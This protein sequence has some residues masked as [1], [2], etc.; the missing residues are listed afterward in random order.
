M[1]E[2][3]LWHFFNALPALG[4]SLAGSVLAVLRPRNAL[5]WLFLSWGLLLAL[6]KL[7]NYV[8]IAQTFDE[9]TGYYQASNAPEWQTMLG[10]LLDLGSLL[11]AMTVILALYPDGRLPA[12]WWRLPVTMVSLGYVLIVVYETV[13]TG[14]RDIAPLLVP[15]LAGFLVIPA[16][17]VILGATIHRWR[18]AVYPYRQQ[19]AWYIGCGLG[20]LVLQYSVGYFGARYEFFPSVPW[21]LMDPMAILPIGV[22]VGVLCYRLLGIRSVIRRGLVYAMLTIL[23]F[24]VYFSVTAILGKVLEGSGLST[25]LVVAVIAVLLAP[26]RDRLQR[27]ADRIVY[28]ARNDP[29]QVLTDLGESVA[30]GGRLGLL[31]AAVTATAAAVRADGAQIVTQEGEVL[32]TVGEFPSARYSSFPL[33]FDGEA[34]GELRMTDPPGDGGYSRTERRLITALAAQLAVV[35]RATAL[36]DSL[37]SER[38]RVV[39]A[40]RDER[41]RLRRDLHDGLGPSLAGMGL[42]LQALSGMVAADSPA[43]TMVRRLRDETDNAVRDIRRIIDAL[44]PTALDTEGLAQAVQRHAGTLGPALPVEVNAASLPTLGPDVEVTAYRIITEALTNVAR[45][46][47]AHH[48]RVRISADEALHIEVTDDG[49]GIRDLTTHSGV[50]LTSMRRRA[51]ALGGDLAVESTT[52]GTTVSATLPLRSE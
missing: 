34:L 9:S 17:V 22:A 23:V 7:G 47:D 52:G 20:P 36:A 27:A 38:F 31:P 30:G 42:G 26:A 48:A 41:D 46:A 25:V 24:G 44:R 37:S 3:A 10:P 18:R 2:Y 13:F 29:L 8:E 5:G 35:V 21:A 19:L 32:A 43:A 4:W 28:G 1:S 12:R 49:H 15:V 50:G 6:L 40:T 11:G 16:T 45:H 51:E 33:R 14:D 39:T